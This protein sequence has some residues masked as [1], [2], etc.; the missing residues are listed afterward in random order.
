VPA[1]PLH[2]EPI[3]EVVAAGLDAIRAEMEIQDLPAAAVDEADAVVA[4]GPAVGSPVDLTDLP[5]VTIDPPGSRDLDQALHVT[6]EADGWTVHYA[7]ADLAAFVRPGGAVDEAARAR[8]V[9]IYLPDAK[10]PLHPPSLSEGAA[11]LLADQVRRALVWRVRIDRDGEVTD[12]DVRRAVV[13]SRGAYSYDQVQAALDAGTADDVFGLLRDAGRA[14]EALQARRGG[15]DLRLPEQNV[16]V[17]DGRYQLEYRAPLPVEGW[18]AQMSLLVGECAARLMLDAGVGVLRTMPPPSTETVDRLRM[19]ARGLG[20]AWPDTTGYAEFVRSLDP[21]DPDQAA[22]IVQSAKLARGAGY[23]AF[24]TAPSGDVTHGAVAA[25]YAHVTAPLR[26]LVDRFAN[27]VTYAACAGTTP[28]DWATSSL[29]DLPTL[30]GKAGSRASTVEK[31]VVSL[32]EAVVLSSCIDEKVEGV[33]VDVGRDRATVQLV[34]PAVVA[35]ISHPRGIELGDEITL[36][37]VSAD[38]TSRSVTLEPVD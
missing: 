37:V 28:P 36:R 16:V 29:P 27:E 20:V 4:A 9:T 26:R 15:L 19:H 32:A 34:R 7:V 5:F 33:V 22:L 1:V 24:T 14:R 10:S 8:G 25:P 35:D 13:R 3:D 23:L 2:V 17:V 11:S 18:N 30:M 6:A 31:M 12:V 38:P 21:T